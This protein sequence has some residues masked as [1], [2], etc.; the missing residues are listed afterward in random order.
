MFAFARNLR[1]LF[2][3]I[4]FEIFLLKFD[5]YG[6]RI[7]KENI[8]YK[9]IFNSYTYEKVGGKLNHPMDHDQR[10]PI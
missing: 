7:V 2:A 1:Q 6:L 9:F 5:S 8:L 4:C 3:I 10:L